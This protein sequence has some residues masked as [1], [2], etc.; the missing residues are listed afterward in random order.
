MSTRTNILVG[1][2]AAGTNACPAFSA[3][4]LLTFIS[5]CLLA[6]SVW[7]LAGCQ[8]PQKQTPR[9]AVS[10]HATTIEDL[11]LRLGL[12]IEERGE[13][14]VILKNAANTVLIFTHTDGRFF[15]NGKPMGPVGRVKNEGGTL[16]VSDFLIP[17]IRE[18]LSSAAPQPPVTRPAPTPRTRGLVVIDAGHGG[19]DPGTTS[20]GGFYEKDINLQVALRVAALLEQNGIGVL[21]TRRDD[22]YPELEERANLANDHNADLFV[23]IHCDSN[24]DRSRQGFTTFIA[25]SASREA[26]QVAGRIN[27]AMAATGSDSHGTREA[28]YKVLVN[29]RCPA[30]LVEIGHLSNSQDASRLRNP[31]W[32]NRLAQAIVTG[33][34]EYLR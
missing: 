11:A 2:R 34:L 6:F 28:D 10:E 17:Q 21:M 13:S 25:R 22:R 9:I 12:R 30:V 7:G 8:Q 18:N 5:S 14:F 4:H 3:P 27:E 31:A 23:S 32:Q 26:N 1:P 15:V 29:T 16:Y 24:P 20:A 19:S 33:I